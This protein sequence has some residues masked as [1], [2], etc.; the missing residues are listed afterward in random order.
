MQ[1]ISLAGSSQLQFQGHVLPAL[2]IVESNDLK[3]NRRGLLTRRKLDAGPEFAITLA[4]DPELD[5]GSHEV[6][7]AVRSGTEG[8]EFLRALEAVPRYSLG[9]TQEEGSLL[10]NWYRAQKRGSLYI[11]KE[12]LNDDRAIERENTF[13]R[14]VDVIS[15][16]LL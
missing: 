4:S 9:S 12:I 10:D 3:H 13:L 6:F 8:E 1:R 14:K 2:P 11:G 7:G 5:D 16:T 15:C